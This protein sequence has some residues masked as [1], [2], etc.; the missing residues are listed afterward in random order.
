MLS[1]GKAS[2]VIE[3]PKSFADLSECVRK[4][5]DYNDGRIFPIN[6]EKALFQMQSRLANGAQLRL[7]KEDGKIVAW[8][9]YALEIMDLNGQRAV[10]QLF[11]YSHTSPIRAVKYAILLHEEMLEWGRKK[12]ASIGVSTC[13]HEDIEFKLCKILARAGWQQQGYLAY[14]HL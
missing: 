9:M 13:S 8:I 14:K 7:I 4:Y 2:P 5:E 1:N 3:K 6:T 11:Y 10:R 12:Y